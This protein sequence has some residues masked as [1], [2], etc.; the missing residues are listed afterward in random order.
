MKLRIRSQSALIQFLQNPSYDSARLN[1]S[2]AGGMHACSTRKTTALTQTSLRHREG[3][4][5]FLMPALPARGRSAVPAEPPMTGLSMGS[6]ISFFFLTTRTTSVNI[7]L[8][9][10][11]SSAVSKLMFLQRKIHFAGCFQALQVL[12]V[13]APPHTS[14]DLI[15]S[16]T[17]RYLR[18]L[19]I[20]YLFAPMLTNMCWKFM[21]RIV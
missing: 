6:I 7:I 5:R 14:K 4:D 18:I 21:L 8:H 3:L 2:T 9:I 19:L 11:K 15:F 16:S 12:H 20:S 17:V 1:V 13:F 10:V